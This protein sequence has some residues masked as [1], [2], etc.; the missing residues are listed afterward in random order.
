[1]VNSLEIVE[2]GHGKDAADHLAAGG[3]AHTFTVV[4]EPKPWSPPPELAAL[5]E[6][7]R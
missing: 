2:A 1:M 6:A 7:A 4:A 3:S 5:F